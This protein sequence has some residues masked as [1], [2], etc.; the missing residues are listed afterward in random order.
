MSPCSHVVNSGERAPAA[1]MLT[2]TPLPGLAANVSARLRSADAPPAMR[3]LALVAR[4]SLRLLSDTTCGARSMF[5][6]EGSVLA[7][8]REDSDENAGKRSMHRS[9][10]RRA[11]T[12]GT[13]IS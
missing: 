8:G 6:A 10:G 3:Q 11:V 2:R 1:G 7:R 9:R 12:S 5:A 4:K 13:R